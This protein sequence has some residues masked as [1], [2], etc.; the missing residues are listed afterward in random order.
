MKTRNQGV[1]FY[2]LRFFY[3]NHRNV[4]SYIKTAEKYCV[5]CTYITFA[6]FVTGNGEKCCQRDAT[7]LQSQSGGCAN[8]SDETRFGSYYKAIFSRRR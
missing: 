1:T 6:L 3:F 7:L 2:I 4:N 8:K 5:V